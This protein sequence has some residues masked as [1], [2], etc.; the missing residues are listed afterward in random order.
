M[1]SNDEAFAKAAF[2]A[3]QV[4]ERLGRKLTP[5]EYEGYLVWHVKKLQNPYLYELSF[6]PNFDTN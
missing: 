4:E 5:D 2:A 1:I 3:R 6:E